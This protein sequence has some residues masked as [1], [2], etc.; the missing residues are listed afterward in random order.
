LREGNSLAVRGGDLLGV[1]A[2]GVGVGL[3]EN[4][5]MGGGGEVWGGRWGSFIGV[6][7]VGGVGLGEVYCGQITEAIGE[8]KGILWPWFVTQRKEG[9]ERCVY[10]IRQSVRGLDFFS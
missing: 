3:R 1:I 6:L 7:G 4:F 9:G 5:W 10:W 8:E 2:A